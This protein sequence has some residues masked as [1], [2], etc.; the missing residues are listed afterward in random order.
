M[1]QARF[2][3]WLS[4]VL[5]TLAP[6]ALVAQGTDEGESSAPSG[7][8]SS[9]ESSDTWQRSFSP[10]SLAKQ[11]DV[12]GWRF[13]VLAVDGK[14]TTHEAASAL[15]SALRETKARRVIEDVEMGDVAGEGD[16]AILESLADQPADRFALV[17]TFDDSPDQPP[18][19]VVTL[20][21]VAGDTVAGF[22]TRKGR[23]EG[24]TKNEDR[25]SEGV[26]KEASEQIAAIAENNASEREEALETFRRKFLWF[27]EITVVNQNANVVRRKT[28][29]LRGEQKKRIEG[30][31]F[32]EIIGRQT[33][34]E[35]YTTRRTT[36]IVLYVLGTAGTL[37]STGL[38]ISGINASTLDTS[39][40]DGTETPDPRSNSGRGQIVAGGVLGGLSAITI[41]A[42]RLYNPHP[43]SAS[44]RRTL[45]DEYNDRLKDE[46]DLSSDVSAPVPQGASTSID[47]DVDVNVGPNGAG[48][49][50][51]LRF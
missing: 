19:A 17:R 1:T 31:K 6:C 9:Q 28:R 26:S 4:F 24:G 45:A 12:D 34:A 10:E 32:Y 46:L 50:M 25:A 35:K 8:E 15:A 29:A 5:A 41:V 49:S 33:L 51:Q 20:Y 11:F 38:L 14:A 22:S 48:A 39:D 27:E 23:G 16:E 36:R 7:A 2:V 21:N 43:V 30:V 44:K 42:A 40:L 47:Y 18:R 37:G 13:A 3:S